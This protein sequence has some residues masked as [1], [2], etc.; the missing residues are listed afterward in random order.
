[1]SFAAVPTP[2]GLHDPLAARAAL[3]LWTDS[4][5]TEENVYPATLTLAPGEA[6]LLQL[7]D[8]SHAWSRD[9]AR[10]YPER[11]TLAPGT[12]SNEPGAR[13]SGFVSISRA[14]V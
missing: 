8:G 12:G 6:V 1:V 7:V 10:R 4:E 9:S 2:L 11:G 3:V 5:R 14:G 13:T